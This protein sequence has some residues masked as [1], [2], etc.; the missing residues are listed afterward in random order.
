MER[1]VE[2]LEAELKNRQWKPADLARAAKLPDAT[3][4]R[5]LNG[6]T[7]AGVEACNALAKA[8]NEPPEKV[9]R[10]AGLL[11]P[12]PAA[13][14]TTTRELIDIIKELSPATREEL[15][16][17]VRFLYQQDKQ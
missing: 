15:L 6:R 5:I 7:Q 9:F 13:E 12:L 11:P 14:D 8:L 3:I 2:W 4:S 10:L 16:K 17:Y 1:L